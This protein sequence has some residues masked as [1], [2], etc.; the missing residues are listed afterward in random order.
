MN[1]SKFITRFKECY[2]EKGYT[3]EELA[4]KLNL[5]INGLKYYLRTKNDK[6]PPLDLL[7][8]MA[9]ILE[10]DTAY[11]LEEIDC[12][13]ISLQTVCDCTYLNVCICFTHFIM[14]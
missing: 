9:E 7:K 12:K 3:Q 13:K 1:K 2:K 5:S 8:R 10:V 14:A 11:L 6:L 4:E